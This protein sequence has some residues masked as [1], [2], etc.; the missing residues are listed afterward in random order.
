MAGFFLNFFITKLSTKDF[1][2]I[3]GNGL[4]V[5]AVR[6]INEKLN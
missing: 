3:A 4:A 6:I 1:A 5:G 2:P